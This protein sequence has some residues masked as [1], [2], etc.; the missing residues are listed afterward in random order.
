MSPFIH[1][2]L[3]ELRG[4]SEEYGVKDIPTINSESFSQLR[5]LRGFNVTI[6]HKTAV[7]PFLDKLDPKAELFGSVN[8]VSNDGG[9]LTGYTT[10]GIG[11]L[12]AIEAGGACVSEKTLLLGCGGAARVVAYEAALAGGEIVIAARCAEKAERLADDLRQSIPGTRVRCTEIANLEKE[13]D[14][15]DLAVNTTPVGMYP[16]AGASVVAEQ[17]VSR[18]S[19][20]FDAVYNPDETQFIRLAQK[21]GK[22]AIR[23]MAMLVWQAA[24]AHEIWDGSQYTAK[25]IDLLCRESVQEMNRIFYS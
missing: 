7:I 11:F 12:R 23:G 5:F 21:C 18:C 2:R 9:V 4:K 6:P 20:V 10:D 13:K 8:T 17:V 24:A 14:Q 16:K 25:E 1:K 15:Y 3:F 22:T 19:A